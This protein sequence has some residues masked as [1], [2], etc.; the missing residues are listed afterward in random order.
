MKGFNGMEPRTG[1]SHNPSN[2]NATLA[3][4]N[5]IEGGKRGNPK[6]PRNQVTFLGGL[7]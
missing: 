5:E 3:A 6:T 4:D 1:V 2:G 7:S